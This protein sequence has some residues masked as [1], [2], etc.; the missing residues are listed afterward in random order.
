MT[1]PISELIARH[2]LL[3]EGECLRC[4]VCCRFPEPGT[5]LAPYFSHEEMD[6]AH[7]SGMPAEAFPPGRY[8]AGHSALLTPAGGV[9]HCP[10]FRSEGND[11]RIYADR[12]MDCR[13]Y[14]WM[15]MYD[16]PGGRV[17]LGLDSYCPAT[18]RMA[19]PAVQ[20]CAAELAA[21]LEGPLRQAVRAR[22]GVVGAWK[23]HVR[24]LRDLPALSKELCRS[25]LGLARL[26]PTARERLAPFFTG[27][28]GS[29]CGQAFAPIYVWS[30]VFDLRWKV[31]GGRVLL[32]A[33]GDGDCFLIAP[34][35]GTGEVAGAADEALSLMRALDPRA[36]SPRIQETDDGDA[37][38]LAK[39]GWRIRDTQVQYVYSRAELADLRGS[40]YE[41]K[42]QLC[43]RFER[44]RVW[45]WRAF[46]CDDLSPAMAL[47]RQWMAGR[48]AAH[49]EELY[50]AQAEASF[51]S[52]Y[53]TLRDAEILGITARVLEAGGQM[54]GITLGCPLP[55]GK[56]FYVMFE[57]SDLR[58]K[59]SAQ[60]M[61]REFC[62][63]MRPFEFISAG[64][65]SLLPNLARVKESYRPVQRL[66]AHD[67][68]PVLADRVPVRKP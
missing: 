3:G 28:G 26:V 52:L 4:E 21:A 13:L 66:N 62:R 30:D 38:A 20:A 1:D 54:A 49:P 27:H 34:P 19:D 68:V 6:P 50:A 14:P 59:G 43:N 40:R 17:L 48:A 67:M 8:G 56:S 16:E 15:L 31:S 29:L 57:I 18:V 46:E 9:F 61:F 35:L 7:R 25:D 42:R 37:R 65:A 44:E 60:V 58:L 39:A 10:A 5:P 24:V 47:Y 23:E 12:P 45:R 2:G 33:T 53:R 41:K 64:S 22:P 63:E 11:C 32:L 36:P 51:R 55:D